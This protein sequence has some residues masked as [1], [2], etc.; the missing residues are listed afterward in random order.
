MQ[1][2]PLVWR[3]NFTPRDW[4]A[5]AVPIALKHLER[6]PDQPAVI[7]A[8]P[9]SGKS[10]VIAAICKA[11]QLESN[12]VVVI[13][14]PTRFL[15]RQLHK[16]CFPWVFPDEMGKFFSSQKSWNCR[17]VVAC[18]MSLEK[19][20]TILRENGRKVALWIAD[21]AHRSEAPTMRKAHLELNPERALA[22]TATAF[23]ASRKERL[24][25]WK[26]LLYDYGPVE[27][28]RD[29]VVVPWRVV[30]YEGGVTLRDDACI[31][32]LSSANGPGIVSADSI[33]DAEAFAK[34]LTE[35][36]IPAEPVHCEMSVSHF[37]DALIRLAKRELRMLVHVSILQEGVNIPWLRW[38]CLRRCVTSRV[39]FVQE[40]GRALRSYPGKQEAVIYDPH[41]LFGLFKLDYRAVLGGISEKDE[42]GLEPKPFGPFPD[43]PGTEDEIRG[44]EGI[45]LYLRQLSLAFDAC[46][47]V[48]R[49]VGGEWRGL[50]VTGKQLGY[51]QNLLAFSSH[52]CVPEDHKH[53]M[54][55]LVERRRGL[56]RGGCSDLISV[57][58]GLRNHEKWPDLLLPEPISEAALVPYG[59]G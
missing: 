3:K 8:V 14:T 11:T 55:E 6:R 37:R 12:E 47:F 29:K 53:C 52:E 24:S 15:V 38:I 51:L 13:S 22:F 20:A 46:G 19:L 34:R 31:E 18:G 45:E 27:A 39:R 36:N 25:L 56:T 54:G 5:K 1:L 4:Q 23:R 17:Y 40:V 41:D 57:L 2:S 48:E 58:L 42:L 21:E 10:A 32:M 30:G 16:E 35:N 28:L 44:R 26:K 43:E 7:R 9:G 50:P 49:F 59:E 33:K